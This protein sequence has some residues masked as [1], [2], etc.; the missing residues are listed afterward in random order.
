MRK[1]ILFLLLMGF[2]ISAFA[3]TQMR[4]KVVDKNTR[5][6]LPGATIV[7]NGTTVGVTT[8]IDGEF[9]LNV[10]KNAKT[11]S[12]SFIGYE[13]TKMNVAANVM[14]ELL[15]SSQSV[16]EVVVV[17]YGVMRK[18]DVT[19]SVAKVKVEDIRKVTTIDAAQ[20][21]QGRVAGVNV[22]SN[23][24]NPGSG[25]KIRIRGI[26]TINNSDPLFVVDGFPMSDI[27]HI[28]PTD[29]ES[30]E[31][32]KDA[33]AT[34]IYGSRGANGVILIKTRSGS[35]T[36]KMEVQANVITGFSQVARQL[37]LADATQF[38][39]ARKTIGATDDIIN[40]V[41]DQQTAGNYLKGTD[42]Q[43]EIYRQGTNTRYNVSILGG[44]DKYSFDHGVTYSQDKGIVK[45]TFMNKLMVH[46][47]NN[48]NLSSKVKIGLNFNYVH[49]EK[50]GEK[51]DYYGGTI[52]GALR[53]D[54]ISAAWDDYTKYYG[55][56][57]YSQAA[58]NPALAIYQ[59][60]KQ[61]SLGN[62]VMGNFFL[63]LDDLFTK[64]LSFRSQYGVMMDFNDNKN[65]S[66]KY[67]ITPTQKNDDATLYQQRQ[68]GLNWVNTNY[69]SYNKSI[70][71]LNIN[72]TLGAELQVSRSSDIWATGYNV[73]ETASLQYL[74]T[75]KDAVKFQL[76]GGQSENR[77]AS[78]F[79][80]GNFAWDNKYV[81]T[82]TMRM[83]GSS[84]FTKEKRWGY[85]PS[86]SGGWVVSN[87]GF[88]E[89]TKS[90]N[91]GSRLS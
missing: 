17:G 22:M 47:N 76:G 87:E 43:K 20:A 5:E 26:G 65:Y 86:I 81:F 52:P 45:G 84:K 40:Y 29:M 55:E 18:S 30:M 59:A 21:I 56:I 77:L 35:K 75:H 11:I 54:P 78:T 89:S 38:A 63:Q 46:S 60:G 34:A 15:S 6:P 13:T 49:F 44:S 91:T 57:Y 7:A 39:N 74:G 64:G 71:K 33:S 32:L 42:W 61:K 24:G 25:V 19:G 9:V 23:S 31:V 12:V 88:M 85:F 90:W 69:F 79:V 37:K 82:G 70:Q 53:S 66:P 58:T 68:Y 67:F 16:D 3:Q 51:T 1:T 72:A 14:I 36:G 41:L 62:K 80:R 48:Y 73:P 27:S 2:L 8:N 10:P 83:D 4:G 28:A 50:P